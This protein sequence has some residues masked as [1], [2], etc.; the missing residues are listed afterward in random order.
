MAAV[1]SVPVA[2]SETDACAECR[3]DVA[4]VPVADSATELCAERREVRASEPEAVSETVAVNALSAAT[5][6]L[7]VADSSIEHA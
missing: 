1:V 5:L 3:E 7:A 6:S 2:V 4:S